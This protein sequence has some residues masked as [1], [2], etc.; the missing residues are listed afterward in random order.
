[1]N[2]PVACGGTNTNAASQ[3]VTATCSPN[4]STSDNGATVT[5]SAVG[6]GGSTFTGWSGQSNLSSSSCT[7]TTTPC[8]AVLGSGP[9]LTATFTAP[10]ATVTP[11]A[12]GGAISAATA[13]GAYTTL[14]GPVIGENGTGQIGVGT[15][16]LNA[17]TG[18]IFDIGG[19][20]PTVLV[21]RTAGSG[22]N[23]LNIN[24]QP[25]GTSAAITLR[26]TT[27]ITFTVIPG[28]VT[29]AGVRNSL[30][31]QNVRVRPTAGTPLASGNITK[32][33]TSSIAGV[34]GTTNFGTLT[35]VPG[36]ASKL[37]F[38]Q[39]PTTTVL[40]QTISPAVTVRVED[41]AGNLIS[42]DTR[43]ITL[44][45]GN[46]PGASTLGG[47]TSSAAVGGVATFGTLSLNHAGTGYTLAAS[48]SP[49]LTGATSS[50]FDITQASQTITFGALANKTYGDLDFAVSATASSGLAVSFSSQT[51]LV[52]TVVGTT[53]HI[54][55]SGSCT[56]RASQAGNADYTAAPNVDQAF[57]IG[58]ATAVV[59]VTP[60]DV[61]Y[62]GLPHTA[63]GRIDHRRERR[64][65]GDGRHGGREQH[66]AHRRRDVCG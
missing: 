58:K 55:A 57:T 10:N 22:L 14:T 49:A 47:T 38:A 36:P 9:A 17:P 29:S 62:D 60:Y 24:D 27:T 63:T 35:E 39:Q 30:T 54:V 6:T 18:F 31:W 1:M 21:T 45:I 4:I 20:T 8:S 5:F 12:G 48:S 32:S 7:G 3:T 41:V 33:G 26:T 56:I 43:N 40:G 34:T 52:C 13:G 2:A 15:I 37:A 61:T 64:D 53:V 50:A 46:N 25:S 66:D 28:G 59:V 19:S 23:T 42:T 65:G 11:A 51:P 16:T 44:V